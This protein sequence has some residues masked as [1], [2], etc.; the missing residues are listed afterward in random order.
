MKRSCPMT[1]KLT[2]LV[3]L[4][5][6][7]EWIKNRLDNLMLS[8]SLSDIEIWCVNANSPDERDDTIPKQ[9]PIRYVR[10][11]NRIS[12][13]ET[14]N[15]II[16]NSQSDYI[17]NANADDIVAPIAYYQLMNVLDNNKN[18]SFAYPS[19]YCTNVANQQWNTLAHVDR[20]G[21]PGNY[22]G[23]IGLAGVGHFPMW[24]RSL[25][26]KIGLFDT[27][28]KAMAD[29]EWWARSYFKGNAKFAW[30]DKYLGCYLDRSGQNLWHTMINPDEWALYHKLLE[31]YRNAPT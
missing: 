18:V 25:H 26:D 28:F 1:K 8:T 9:Y 14:W 13:Y 7:G 16:S 11:D 19:W 22:N 12:V 30:L 17:T 3:S 24:R 10:L 20:G 6:A 27:R 29:A 23:D 15:Y 5:N 4:Y 2:V 21:R 31:G